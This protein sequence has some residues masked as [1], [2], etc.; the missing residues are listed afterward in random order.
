MTIAPVSDLHAYFT[1]EVSRA[2]ARC[3]VTARPD[4]ARYLGALLASRGAITG[5]DRS[6]VLWLDRAIAASAPEQRLELQSLGDHAL[7][8][9]GFFRREASD[10]AVYVRVG[11]YAYERAAVLARSERDPCAP[12][13]D[14]LSSRFD[15]LSNVLTEV[16]VA[17]SLGAKTRD[18]VRLFDAW[19]QSRSPS[20]LA[21]MTDAGVFPSSGEGDA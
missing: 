19:K 12:V 10:D 8:V 16:A 13:L 15:A 3:A 7:Y 20:A 18:L 5:P 9:R 14:E 4:V 1:D 11:Q 21:A 2:C 6:I 17:S